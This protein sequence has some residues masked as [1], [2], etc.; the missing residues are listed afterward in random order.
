MNV[1]G[2]ENKINSS[3]WKYLHLEFKFAAKPDV[4]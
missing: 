3:A 2:N 1:E 4:L